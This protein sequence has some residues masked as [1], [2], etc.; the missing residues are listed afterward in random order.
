VFDIPLQLDLTVRKIL[1]VI[2]TEESVKRFQVY[3][4]A[5]RKVDHQ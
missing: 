2:E 5:V 1:L 3:L 4:R